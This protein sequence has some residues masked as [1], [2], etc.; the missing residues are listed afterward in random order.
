MAR[1]SDSKLQLKPLWFTGNE[2]SSGFA[3]A[4]LRLEHTLA[5]GAIKRRATRE[6]LRNSSV[7]P[8]TNTIPGERYDRAEIRF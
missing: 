3:V 4:V 1:L 8:G 5:T 6:T 7:R 2:W